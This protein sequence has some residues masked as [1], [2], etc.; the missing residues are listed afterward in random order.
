MQSTKSTDGTQHLVTKMLGGMIDVLVF[1]NVG[2]AYARMKGIECVKTE[3]FAFVDAD[4]V[5]SSIWQE[6]MEAAL[7]ALNTIA[8][9]REFPVGAMCGYLYRNGAHLQYLLGRNWWHK[10]ECRL[11]THN[12]VIRTSTVKGWKPDLRVNA[13]EDYLLTQHLIKKGYEC[14][15]VGVL[16]FHDHRGSVVRA[17]AWNSAGSRYLG[18]SG[19]LLSQVP[20]IVTRLKDA[21][22]H[23]VRQRSSWFITYAFQQMIGRIIG[24][25]KWSAYLGGRNK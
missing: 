12:T 10:T 21:M 3:W 23:A 8:T 6:S 11:F 14:W 1:E 9:N 7:Y 15:F 22:I 24:H 25:I 13:W 19:S 5:L 16:G 4:V 20:F 2:L 18:I 17:S